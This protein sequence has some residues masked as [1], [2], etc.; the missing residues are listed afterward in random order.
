V[1]WHAS[2][3]EGSVLSSSKGVI[4][5]GGSA[6]ITAYGTPYCSTSS[7]R[8]TSNGGKRTVKIIWGGPL[9]SQ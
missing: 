6:T 8:F 3:T 2:I 4:R 7:V 9:C 1:R 5:A